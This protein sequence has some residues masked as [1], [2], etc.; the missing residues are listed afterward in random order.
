MTDLDR[1]L[2]EVVAELDRMSVPYAVMGAFSNT[3]SI[4]TSSL[5]NRPSRRN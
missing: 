5:P 1:A 3:V 2:R 4:L